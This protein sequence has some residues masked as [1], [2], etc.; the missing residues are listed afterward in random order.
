MKFTLLFRTDLFT[1]VS[2][3]LQGIN[4]ELKEFR[5]MPVDGIAENA[6]RMAEFNGMSKIVNG[7]AKQ[8]E[9]L[10]GKYKHYEELNFEV[11][12]KSQISLQKMLT[13]RPP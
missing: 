9:T 8:Y 3:D 5:D 10:V 11:A 2:T 13:S 4:H 6:I 12:R 1:K 7:I